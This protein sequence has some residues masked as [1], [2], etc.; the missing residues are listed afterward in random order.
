M[1]H[2]LPLLAASLAA[3]L[4][5]GCD[6][7]EDDAV[8]VEIDG[9]APVSLAQQAQQDG[10]YDAPPPMTIDPA[11]DYSAT[12]TT[13]RG[14]ITVDLF[15]ADAP[16]TVNNFVFLAGEDF[17]DGTIFHRVIN[18]FMIQG[19]DPTGTGRGG[20]GYRF[21][22]ETQGNPNT[23]QPF[24]LSM[25]NSGPDTNGSQFF[26]TEVAT[27]HLD[28][29]HTVFGR[30]TEGQDVVETISD[31]DT[32][33]G[34]RPVEDVVIEHITILIDGQPQDDGTATRPQ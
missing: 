13:N 14:E 31:V 6:D 10:K 1:K 3:S 16:A 8:D 5:V 27:P 2:V 32:A 29:K 23:H 26:I 19:G 15:E 12:I 20:P 18:E 22:D 30:V 4:A 21:A 33:A 17:Y 24:T 7:Q 34:N 28:G 11:Q 25:A 9:L